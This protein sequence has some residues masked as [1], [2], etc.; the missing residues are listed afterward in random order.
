M[1]K[2]FFLIVLFVV[3]FILQQS[4]FIET[5]KVVDQRIGVAEDQYNVNW[6]NLKDYLQD[7]PEN[8]KEYFSPKS[9]KHHYH[10]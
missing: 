4:H 7:L 8:L 5:K 6:N 3:V 1:G 9:K 10:R 2:L